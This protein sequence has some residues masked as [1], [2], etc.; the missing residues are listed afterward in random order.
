MAVHPNILLI[1]GQQQNVGKTTLACNIIARFARH[2]NI[3]ALK[4]TPHFHK[5]VGNANPIIEGDRFQI[6]EETKMEG[7]KDTARMLRAG[8][9]KSYLIQS[10]HDSLNMALD[11]FGGLI[12][13]NTP[14]ICESAGVREHIIPS[15][16]FVLRRL[17]C[18]ICSAE[19]ENMFKLA[20]R[21]V[22]FTGSGFD[23]SIDRLIY[24]DNKWV[25]KT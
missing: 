12:P 21:I 6:L 11:A 13:E 18:K 4:V 10:N 1:A 25:L 17:N 2:L 24:Y 22:T 5:N 20:T 23:I 14:I 16:F 9:N 19:D 15:V 8:A 7:N 3:I